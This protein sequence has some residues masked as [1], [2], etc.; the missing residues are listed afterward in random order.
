VKRKEK[1]MKLLKHIAPQI[2]INNGRRSPCEC[3][4]TITCTYCVQ[5]NLLGLEKKFKADESTTNNIVV[6]IKR[7]GIRQTA[8][9]L[10]VQDSNVRYWLKTK[11]VPQFVIQ[12]YAGCANQ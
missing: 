11:N 4:D 10:N 8:R 7:N 5:A 1:E 2:L 3:T 6:Y 12:K 9:E